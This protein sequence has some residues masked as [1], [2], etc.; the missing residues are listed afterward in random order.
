VEPE[1]AKYLP[2]IDDYDLSWIRNSLNVK[3]IEINQ[4]KSIVVSLIDEVKD[5]K[6][7]LNFA[8]LARQQD[9][10][11][12]GELSVERDEWRQLAVKLE[13]RLAACE[14]RLDKASEFIRNKI[15]KE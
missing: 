11:K 14:T 1:L 13:E 5:F 6:S 10:L 12:L 8:L 2:K 7:Q 15:G 4:F 9:A 3:S